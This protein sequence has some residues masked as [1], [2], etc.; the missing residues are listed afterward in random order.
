[1]MSTH[2]SGIVCDKLLQDGPKQFYAHGLLDCQSFSLYLNV[3][4]SLKQG[5]KCFPAYI[6]SS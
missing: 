5:W 3:N 6:T 4:I 2:F 1:M